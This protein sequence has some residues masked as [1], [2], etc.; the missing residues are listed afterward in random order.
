MDK[1]K[2]TDSRFSHVEKDPRFVRPSRRKN[3]VVVDERFTNRL[4]GSEF[5]QKVDK[6]GR[7]KHDSR[8][9]KQLK[10]FYVFDKEKAVEK[11]KDS[12]SQQESSEESDSES[13][14][15][16]S[17]EE[18]DSTNVGKN[19][20]AAKKSE[21]NAPK[22]AVD[23]ARGEG[24]S[25]ESSESDSDS[26]LEDSNVADLYDDGNAV[27]TETQTNR[28]A[29]VNMDW[30]NL[31]AV[32]LLAA[33]MA[34]KPNIGSILDVKIYMSDFGKERISK[35]TLE[36]PPSAIYLPEEDEEQESED[37]SSDSENSSDA[38][39]KPS[40][41][42]EHK[43]PVE[44]EEGKDFD[45]KALRKY[46]LDKLKY[47]YAVATCDS[48]STAGSV[49]ENI[50]STE[51]ESSA[52]LFDLRF[53]PDD[54]SFE[55]NEPVD[56]ATRV[57]EN[58]KPIEFVTTALQHSQVKLTWDTEDPKRLEL[59]KRATS[60]DMDLVDYKSF[61][62]SSSE[63]ETEDKSKKADIAA[64]YRE[65]LLGGI[66][67]SSNVFGKKGRDESESDEDD[68][69][70]EITFA[71]GLSSRSFSDNKG[72]FEDTIP[73]PENETSLEKYVRKQKERRM[74]KS[75]SKANTNKDSEINNEGVD[76][77]DPFLSLTK[78]ESI[79]GPAEKRRSGKGGK[80]KAE[81]RKQ[82]DIE[83]AELELLMADKEN[84]HMEHFDINQIVKSQKKSKSKRSR[85]RAELD[86]LQE[87]FTIDTGDSR[88]SSVYNSSEFAID[89]N[90][91]DFKKTK[92]MQALLSERRKRQNTSNE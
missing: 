70:M 87:N 32:D 91:K 56:V 14:A 52:N 62:A 23:R 13:E 83:R 66:D 28:L 55:D 19:D 65:L 46:E 57:P 51:F 36:G 8:L 49:Y 89:P 6:Y 54:V 72:D 3:K 44:Y 81:D 69:D 63:E 33:F 31:R 50:D 47:Y 7:K 78:E 48:A 92:G 73:I 67:D 74:K 30:E 86:G 43:V 61:L 68:V 11:E 5:M 27:M 45:Q 90:V 85:N 71:P 21:K 80:S 1:D 42:K 37:D 64:K 20:K 60:K 77:D 16:S 17:S 38:E 18:S 41:K 35:E 10:R 75:L 25:D 4:D 39:K 12:D 34:F 59:K 53:V 82:K 22:R 79:K 2:I 24:I 40:T 58:Y 29:I 84:Q 15:S 76:L 9:E 26:D 88:F